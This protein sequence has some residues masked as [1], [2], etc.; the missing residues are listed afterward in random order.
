LSFLDKCRRLIALD[1]S[2][3]HGNKAAAEYLGE[4]CAAAGLHVSYEEEI[5]DGLEQ[6]N[7][8]ARPTSGVPSEELLLQSH[9]DTADA[10]HFAMWTK[11]QSN[12]F[13]ASIDEGLM[14]GLG[15]AESKLDFLC[16]LEAVSSLVASKWKRPVVLAAT[17]GAQ[18]GMAGAIKLVRKKKVH[19]RWALVGS[20]TDMA[21]IVAAQGLAVIEL[22]VPFSEEEKDY[23]RRHDIQE[24]SSSQSRMFAAKIETG[25]S[26]ILKM[27]SY[28]GQL[29]SGIA[30]MDMDGGI[31]S[32]SVPA[33]AVLEIDVM[34]GFHD[35][36]VPKLSSVHTALQAV[37]KQLGEFRDERFQPPHPT[38]NVG[39]IRTTEDGVTL[40]GCC[41][42]PPTVTDQVYEQW[43]TV[44]REACQ[45]N[46]ATF[47][48]RDYRKGFESSPKGELATAAMETLRLLGLSDAP[49]AFTG[50]TEASVFSRWGTECIVWGPGQSVGN[51]QAPNESIKIKDLERA[52]DFYR[53]FLQR[54][55]L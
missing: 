19:A 34:A 28:L 46:G 1:S 12:P 27:L 32:N 8:L 41:R 7:L 11:T 49:R 15:V 50:A 20:P 10:G 43:M 52:V 40:T 36:I 42:L 37:E 29:P 51:S 17:F 4:L 53:R 21:L 31:S 54:F 26:A 39:T 38:M 14:Y 55:C 23:R 35:P 18:R 33:S 44:L 2:P 22:F 9:I 5:L 6:R 16:K 47:R 13:N 30:V 45:A 25:E 3:S 24:S 48:V